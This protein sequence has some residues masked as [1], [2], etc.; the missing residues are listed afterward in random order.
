MEVS[1]KSALNI[2]MGSPCLDKLQAGLILAVATPT[3]NLPVKIKLNIHVFN[4]NAE[5]QFKS[6]IN[7]HIILRLHHSI[8]HMYNMTY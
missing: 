7:K 4:S 8:L 2:L 1:N 6:I 5:N 3:T